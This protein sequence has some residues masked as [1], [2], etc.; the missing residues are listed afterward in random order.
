MEKL[1]KQQ[2]VIVR[3]L[4][5]HSHNKDFNQFVLNIIGEQ[6]WTRD[7]LGDSVEFLTEEQED[8]YESLGGGY[9]S[10][11]IDECIYNDKVNLEISKKL[12]EL[13]E[14]SYLYANE[15]YLD[16]IRQGTIICEG[17]NVEEIKNMIIE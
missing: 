13:G 4:L 16:E 8:L 3:K 17:I 11:E 7:I 9:T 5:H 6:N 15:E 12:K 14:S 10:E 2:E 1:T